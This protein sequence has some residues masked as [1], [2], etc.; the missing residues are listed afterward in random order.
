M[1][2]HGGLGEGEPENTEEERRQTLGRS[3]EA[4]SREWLVGDRIQNRFEMYHILG[5]P[6][7]SGTGMIY[8]C[9]DATGHPKPATCGLFWVARD[10]DSYLKDLPAEPWYLRRMYS[11]VEGEEGNRLQ[12]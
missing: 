3:E 6:G 12:T 2:I 1:G 4:G 11:Y 5:G 10:N 8:V 9:Y 7:K